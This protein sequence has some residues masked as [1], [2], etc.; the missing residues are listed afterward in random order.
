ME[1]VRTRVFPPPMTYLSMSAATA[2]HPGTGDLAR[3]PHGRGASLRDQIHSAWRCSR[4][5]AFKREGASR[6]GSVQN[7]GETA[8][9]ASRSHHLAPTAMPLPPRSVYRKACY[10]DERACPGVRPL[11]LTKL[12]TAQCNERERSRCR[13]LRTAF[14]RWPSRAGRVGCGSRWPDWSSTPES[15]SALSVCPTCPRKWTNSKG[16]PR[17]ARRVMIHSGNRRRNPPQEPGR[18]NGAASQRRGC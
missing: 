2:A 11:R 9:A 16:Q 8:S 18:T 6:G 15:S 3:D 10:A 14:I 13:L 7:S 4:P 12:Q 17:T 5:P 1:L